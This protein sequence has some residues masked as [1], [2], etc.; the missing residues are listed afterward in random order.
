[1]EFVNIVCFVVV[2][3]PC[4]HNCTCHRSPYDGV[5]IFD[6][7]NKGL[8]SLPET[9]LE[10]TDHLLL[11][12]NNLGSFNKAP[13]YLKNIT[14][15]YLRS[16]NIREIDE[17]VM[18]LIIKNVKYLDIRGNYLKKIPQIIT[19]AN[20]ISEL[21]ISDNP[22]ECNCD[23]FWMKDWLMGTRNVQDKDNVTCLQNKG[24]GE[25]TVENFVVM[26]FLLSIPFK[27]QIQYEIQYQNNLIKKA[28]AVS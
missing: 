19:K 13:D 20:N 24:K 5:N 2:P 15:L 25:R 23:M 6:C 27:R 10:D 3:Q 1:M 8:T 14:L 11:S 26:E 12:G 7:Q 18:K 28:I 21:W 17:K 16:S 22:F 9:V 4:L